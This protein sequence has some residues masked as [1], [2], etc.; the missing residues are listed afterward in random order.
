M[1][2]V[3][4]AVEESIGAS[5]RLTVLLE[6]QVDVVEAEDPGFELAVHMRTATEVGGDYYDIMETQAGDKW[7]ASTFQ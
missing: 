3:T 4:R 7:I 2:A 1:Q 6:E 5:E